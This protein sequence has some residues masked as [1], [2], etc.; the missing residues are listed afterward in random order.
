MKSLLKNKKAQIGET[1]QEI[2]G[3][4]LIAFIM[5]ASIALSL[6]LGGI[7]PKNHVKKVADTINKDVQDYYFITSR[8][9]NVYTVDYQTQGTKTISGVELIKLSKF[10]ENAQV[11]LNSQGLIFSQ[12]NYPF[13]IPSNSTL[14]ITKIQTK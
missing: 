5:I 13:K 8:L 4:V 9:N 11:L 14:F 2:V 3:I 6:A 12:E 10:N 7:I 1:I